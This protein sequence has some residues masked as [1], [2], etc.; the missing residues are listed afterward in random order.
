MV[1]ENQIKKDKFELDVRRF[2]KWYV[3]RQKNIIWKKFLYLMI[4]IKKNFN[5]IIVQIT[6][7][8]KKVWLFIE[9]KNLIFFCFILTTSLKLKSH[10]LYA[11][12]RQLLRGTEL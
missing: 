6:V 3:D 9:I 8:N 5:F 11:I 1:V 7:L 12:A 2:A 10:K 4:I